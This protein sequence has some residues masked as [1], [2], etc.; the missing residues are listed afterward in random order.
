V[1]K[2]KDKKG[3]LDCKIEWK[4]MGTIDQCFEVGGEC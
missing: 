2:E 3:E 4:H 1:I